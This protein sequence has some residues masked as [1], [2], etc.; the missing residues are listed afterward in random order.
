[1]TD[2]EAPADVHVVPEGAAGRT[3]HRH[4]REVLGGVPVRRLGA[5]VKSGRVLVDGAPGFVPQRLHGGER[6]E[7][8]E[9][10]R[11]ELLRAAVPSRDLDLRVVFGDDAV[12][13]VDKPKG[14]QVHP[15]GRHRDD[16][17]VGGLLWL[18]GARPD[19][20]WTDWR[21]HVVNRLDR[22][23]SGL[24]AVARSVEVRT[25]LQDALEA[26]RMQRTYLAT[27][28]GE[29]VGEAGTVDRPLGRDPAMD[30]RRAVVPEAEGGQRAVSHWRVVARRSGTTDVEVVL[31][32]GRTHQIRA[33]LA[34]LGHP[35]VG[36]TLY[37][38][39]EPPEQDL[40]IA[41]HA[42]RLSFPHPV[43]G[44]VLELTSPP[45]RPPA[46]P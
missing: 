1:M 18:A 13:V 14:M 41:L 7:L 25:A 5:L 21:P 45:P 2:P 16:T 19:S 38:D 10:V 22:P 4:L 27:V 9:E 31:E 46:G 3:L 23:T 8:E 39:G 44:E 26:G 17:L 42:T 15:M 43:S 6:I 30:Y 28:H 32:T 24:V 33:H 35:I 36:D 11:R 40:R 12:L 37:A 29:V 34:S 20:V